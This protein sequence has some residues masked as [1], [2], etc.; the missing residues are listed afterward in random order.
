MALLD[1]DGDVVDRPD[2]AEALAE[3][4]DVDGASRSSAGEGREAIAS[5]G[6][7]IRE[8]SASRS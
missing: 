4:V 8:S 6:A 7:S 3:V 2:R 5:A 1:L